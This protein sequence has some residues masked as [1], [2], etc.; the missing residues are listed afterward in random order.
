MRTVV[1]SFAL[2]LLLACLAGLAAMA[3]T[4]EKKKEAVD[5]DAGANDPGRKQAALGGKLA[6][7]VKAAESAQAASTA[8]ADDGG[9]PDKGVFAPGSADKAHAAGA[10]PK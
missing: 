2:P 9:P 5:A 1:R 3:C 7:A 8:K 10:A 6:A 4:E